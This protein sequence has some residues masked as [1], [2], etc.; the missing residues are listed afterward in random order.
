MRAAGGFS[1]RPMLWL[2]TA[3]VVL[4]YDGALLLTLIRAG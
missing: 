4:T 3:F 2:L 1:E